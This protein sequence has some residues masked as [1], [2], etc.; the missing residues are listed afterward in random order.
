MK[1]RGQASVP[2]LHTFHIRDAGLPAFSPTLGLGG[3]EVNPFSP[4]RHSSFVTART[5]PPRPGA[6]ASSWLRV[7]N[8]RKLPICTKGI[9]Q[10]RL[11]FSNLKFRRSTRLRRAGRPPLPPDRELSQLAARGQSGLPGTIPTPLSRS[12]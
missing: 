3:R 2:G 7:N 12:A 9:A 11:G 5:P 1:L 8:E 4:S 10:R 6:P